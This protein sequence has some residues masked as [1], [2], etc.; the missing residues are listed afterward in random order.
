[1][2]AILLDRAVYYFLQG[3]SGAEKMLWQYQRGSYGNNPYLQG[4]ERA[5]RVSGK[6]GKGGC[7]HNDDII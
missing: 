4:Q 5:E 3:L 7:R 6:Q 2:K 1:M